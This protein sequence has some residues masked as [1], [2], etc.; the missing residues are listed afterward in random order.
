M[1]NYSDLSSLKYDIEMVTVYR[2]DI[3]EKYHVLT[4]FNFT[5]EEMGP[6]F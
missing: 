4:T 2:Y 5:F 3:P 1:A 6:I